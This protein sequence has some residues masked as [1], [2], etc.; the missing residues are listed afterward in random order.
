MPSVSVQPKE[1][2]AR[3]SENVYSFG[4]ISNRPSL[5]TNPPKLLLPQNLEESEQLRANMGLSRA[6]ENGESQSLLTQPPNLSLRETL[7]FLIT[8]MEMQKHLPSLRCEVIR[9]RVVSDEPAEPPSARVQPHFGPTDAG[10]KVNPPDEKAAE[11]GG[12]AREEGGLA[13]EFVGGK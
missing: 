5:Q 6:A 1:R 13:G 11:G 3:K 2:G 4:R 7:L 12:G 10:N 9:Y 8:L